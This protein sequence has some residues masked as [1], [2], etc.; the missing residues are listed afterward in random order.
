MFDAAA[1][2]MA[3][4]FVGSVPIA[5]P[6]S[7][8]VFRSGIDGHFRRGHG[9]A[10]G[11]A[12]A[13]AAYAFLAFWG[14]SAFLTRYSFVMP[15]SKLLGGVILIAL[16][17]TFLRRPASGLKPPPPANHVETTR[18]F[19]LGFGIT[20]LNPTLIATWTAI[21]A[22]LYS[23]GLT[24]FDPVAAWAFAAGVAVGISLWFV[25]LLALLRRFRQRMEAR[26]LDRMMQAMGVII[27][28]L[29]AYF[30]ISLVPG[31]EPKWG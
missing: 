27:F 19:L 7:A 12:L 4:G 9:I 18:S 26:F 13:E 3:F 11:A 31:L 6:V 10:L 17:I 16:G 14:F 2:G 20:G 1:F 25:I 23:T 15:L 29:G 8:L 5:G 24:K 30:L 28:G 21:V 22:T